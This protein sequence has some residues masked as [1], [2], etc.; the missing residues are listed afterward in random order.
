MPK[1][2][3]LEAERRELP[4]NELIRYLANRA[5]AHARSNATTAIAIV[6]LGNGGTVFADAFPGMTRNTQMR[7]VGELE[8]LKL[9]ILA[10]G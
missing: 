3:D 4:Q 2:L 6:E 7:L 5:A 9:R 8:A 1:P 10:G